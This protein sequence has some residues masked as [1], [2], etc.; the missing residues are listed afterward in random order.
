[1]WPLWSIWRRA[2]IEFHVR[3]RFI[4]CSSEGLGFGLGAG[5]F[6]SLAVSLVCRSVRVRVR[7][8]PRLPS[9]TGG[10][11]RAEAC[12]LIGAPSVSQI[13]GDQGRDRA[14]W[15]GGGGVQTLTVYVLKCASV[16]R[17]ENCP[18]LSGNGEVDPGLGRKGGGG[19]GGVHRWQEGEGMWKMRRA[20][21][22]AASAPDQLEKHLSHPV[23][24][25]QIT[26][27]PFSSVV[28][29]NSLP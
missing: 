16:T 5:R 14:V 21:C 26:A 23:R 28:L 12:L 11:I 27:D 4:V 19:W 3:V 29:R 2:L 17:Q 13:V 7:P 9:T 1:M 15:R 20:G 24:S 25:L 18:A 22:Y 10:S 6:L 8:A